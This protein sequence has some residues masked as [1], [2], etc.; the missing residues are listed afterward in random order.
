MQDEQTPRSTA[1]TVL[2]R[3]LPLIGLA[4]L[5]FLVQP[6]SATPFTGISSAGPL[7]NVWI[8]N[9]L[10]CQVSHV[11]DV[12]FWEVYP[13]GTRPGDCG[14]FA[15]VGATLYA[16]AMS[17]HG[18]TA[19]GSIGAYTAFTP[20]SQ[21]PVTGA[22]TALSPFQI[23]TTVNVGTTGLQIQE[24]T[25]YVIGNPFF[26]TFS[27]ITNTGSAAVD[28]TFYRAIDCY[29]GG[30]D[31]GYGALNINTPG[32]VA[33]TENPNNLPAGRYEEMEPL[34]GGSSYYHH[35]YNTVWTWI[36]GHTPFPNTCQC[37]TYLDN[38]LGL[39]W[40]DHL[41]PGTSVIH[42]NTLRFNPG[43]VTVPD[44]CTM[45]GRA[46][47]WHIHIEDVGNTG[48][49]GPADS[50]SEDTGE[51]A[52]TSDSYR[53]VGLA[54]LTSPLMVGDVVASEVGTST[55]PEC[56][57]DSRSSAVHLDSGPAMPA[58]LAPI[59]IRGAESRAHTQCD[60]STGGFTIAYLE[61]GGQVLI[62]T[63]GTPAPNTQF[64]V[65]PL[66][67]IVNEQTGGPGVFEVTGVH[68]IANGVA[69][70]RFFYARSDI[71]D[72]PG[73]PPEPPCES[74]YVQNQLALE[75]AGPKFNANSLRSPIATPVDDCLCEALAQL[76]I[77][78][79]PCPSIHTQNVDVTIDCDPCPGI[80]TQNISVTVDCDP[81]D[82]FS[83]DIDPCDQTS[84]ILQ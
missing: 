70:A 71:H 47:I 18:G 53:W 11:A 45:T 23:V 69:D 32:S 19:S 9:E 49:I 59:V 13:P 79:D 27:Q 58:P 20:V 10:S 25:R 64:T 37:T 22:G 1:H 5:A 63:A 44:P 12:G 4:V 75:M 68:V 40:T 46:Y 41:Q 3:L 54:N 77:I 39:S 43:E 83:Q 48:L 29:L 21:T 6:V 33:C 82:N 16:P 80:H 61:V 73:L 55:D 7:D 35:N 78:C 50:W 26:T 52:T 2:L 14:S 28:V 31:V 76:G 72:C 30:T 60:Y 74:G 8:G 38:G 36:G 66:T 62:N 67:V 24:T 57:S 34:T 51:V 81:C 17:G 65:G 56:H 42:G 15:V 84:I